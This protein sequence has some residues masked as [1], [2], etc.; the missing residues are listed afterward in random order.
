MFIPFCYYEAAANLL[1]NP[2]LDPFGKIP[3]IQVLRGARDGGRERGVRVS[4]TTS[5]R[6][7]RR[8]NFSLP[9]AKRIA[10]AQCGLEDLAHGVAGKS[11]TK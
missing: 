8:N 10:V 4:D 5:L 7:A 1:T 2:V 11:S 9:P 3:G 6:N